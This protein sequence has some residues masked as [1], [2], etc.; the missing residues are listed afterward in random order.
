MVWLI[1]A[2]AIIVLGVGAWAGTGRLGSMPEVVNDRPKGVIPDGEVDAAFLEE[3][4]LPTVSHGY[5][6]DQVD[7]FLAAHVEGRALTDARTMRF[8][9]VRQG[10][11]MQGVDLI[12]RRIALQQAPA[13][14]D[15]LEVEGD[16]TPEAETE[17][18]PVE[19]GSGGPSDDLTAKGPEDAE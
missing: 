10:Y 4:K 1:V 2:C 18:A 19:A 11:D 12:L 15:R 16:H 8:D 5:D 9:V 14:E 3:V 13:E 6:P 17:E 7:E